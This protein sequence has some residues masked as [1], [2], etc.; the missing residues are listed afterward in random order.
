MRLVEAYVENFGVLHQHYVRFD[1]TISV[2]YAENGH[3]KTT[4]AAFLYAMLYGLHGTMR[5]ELSENARKKYMPW[6]GGAFGGWLEVE[7]ANGTIRITR[8]FGRRPKEDTVRLT[9]TRTG[10]T[11]PASAEGVGEQLL[12]VDAETFLRCIYMSQQRHSAEVPQAL[13]A[14]LRAAIHNTQDPDA[15]AAA[16]RRLEQAIK[17]LQPLR[18]VGGMIGDLQQKQVECKRLWAEKQAQLGQKEALQNRLTELQEKRRQLIA[19]QK[20]QAVQREEQARAEGRRAELERQLQ[21]AKEILHGNMP[22]EELF[23]AAE[24]ALHETEHITYQKQTADTAACDRA[25][26]AIAER[27][28]CDQALQ[29][30]VIPADVRQH[31]K[32]LDRFFHTAMPSIE[33]AEHMKKAADTMRKLKQATHQNGAVSIALVILAA[34]LALTGMFWPITTEAVHVGLFCGGMVLLAAALLLWLFVGKKNRRYLA[35]MEAKYGPIVAQYAPQMPT[36]KA[37]RQIVQYRSEWESVLAQLTHLREKRQALLCRRQEAENTVTEFFA[38]YGRPNEE[39][40]IAVELLRGGV[41]QA[42]HAARAEAEL[43]AFWQ[44]FG[45]IPPKG[46]ERVRLAELRAARA[47]CIRIQKELADLP[48]EKTVEISLSVTDSGITELAAEEMRVQAQLEQ[49][50]V[51]EIEAEELRVRLEAD[52]QRLQQAQ[53]KRELLQKTAEL[54]RQAQE[55]LSAQYLQP[56]RMR[57]LHYFRQAF[58]ETA[59]VG[60]DTDLNLFLNDA[61]AER[62]LAHF[63]SGTQAAVELCMHFALSDL[64][65]S[66]ELPFFILDDP[67][68]YADDRHLTKMLELLRNWANER[69]IIYF[70]CHSDRAKGLTAG[71]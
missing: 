25:E 37:L 67:F 8:F 43:H 65:F 10:N 45:P 27:E 22:T 41:V 71:S 61:G 18:G 30:T 31:A 40:K 12:G 24:Q 64:L 26:A 11:Y 23:A 7:T 20:K 9:N 60:I 36:E 52:A 53:H 19:M 21:H 58:D 57:F 15:F 29:E 4:F 69:Q 63:S 47:Q 16:Q 48:T 51:T 46:H 68:V 54:L 50:S 33:D 62:P 32:M 44:Q 5:R 55:Q 6:Q 13:N 3:G 39:D 17:N 56:L 35:R 66:N 42:V 70:T 49:L 2:F 14:R 59:Q 38:Q 34:V 1:Q 28:A